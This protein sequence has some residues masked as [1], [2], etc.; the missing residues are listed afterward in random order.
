MELS[1]RIGYVST[2]LRDDEI[3]RCLVKSKLALS[4]DLSLHLAPEMERKCSICQVKF[5]VYL[6]DS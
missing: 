1:D 2:G 3:T 6:V 4:T 5:L